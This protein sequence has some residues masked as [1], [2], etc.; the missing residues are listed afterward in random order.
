MFVR[1]HTL[2]IHVD[3]RFPL[4]DLDLQD[5]AGLFL[6]CMI[7]LMLPGESR[8]ICMIQGMFPGLDLYYLVQY[9]DPV[10]YIIRADEDLDDLDRVLSDISVRRVLS[11]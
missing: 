5:R 2:D 6:I 11:F 10:Q 1:F 9:T 3:N 8:A 4:D 7:Q